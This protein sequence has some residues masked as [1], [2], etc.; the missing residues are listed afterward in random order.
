[1]K[2]VL[3]RAFVVGALLLVAS[4]A[5][6]RDGHVSGSVL[7]ACVGLKVVQVIVGYPSVLQGGLNACAVVYRRVV[8]CRVGISA[9]DV[10]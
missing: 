6:C 5:S 3:R 4:P 7:R 9:C 1:M 8:A 2:P 10:C